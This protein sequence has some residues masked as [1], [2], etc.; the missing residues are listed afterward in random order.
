MSLSD[1]LSF[2]SFQLGDWWDK[3]KQ[4]PEQLLIGAGDPFSASLWG[5]LLGKDYEPFVNALGGPQ[6]GGALGLGDNGGVY[7][8]A[9]DAGINTGTAAGLHNVA[10]AVSASYA[11]GFGSDALGGL[12]SGGGTAG[13]DIGGAGSIQNGQFSGLVGSSGSGGGASS[14]LGFNDY[15]NYADQLS[16]L[17]GGGGQPQVDNSQHERA[18]EAERLKRMQSRGLL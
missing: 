7:G 2:E 17:I 15:F 3:I 10:E 16:G 11:G 13:V 5:G 1:A 6:G 9:Q 4:N 8:R 14:G 18:V 12:G